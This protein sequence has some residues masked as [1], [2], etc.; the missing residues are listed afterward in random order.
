MCFRLLVACEPALPPAA[1]EALSTREGLD[2]RA[3]EAAGRAFLEVAWGDCACSLYSLRAGRE[4]VVGFV[5]ALRS[6]SRELQ[7]LLAQD[8]EALTLDSA[9]GLR[10]PPPIR[11]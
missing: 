6:S 9:E 3:T 5:A 4:R 2:V 8:E 1:V 10:P 11:W 7:L